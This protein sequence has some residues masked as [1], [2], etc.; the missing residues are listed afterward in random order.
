IRPALIHTIPTFNN[1]TGTTLPLER[2]RH[3]AE[4]VAHE[5]RIQTAPTLLFED[6][7]YALT[8]FEGGSLPALFDL[9]GK[10]S[11]YSSSFSATLGPGLRV[12]W[13]IVPQTLAAGLAGSC[14]PSTI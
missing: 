9:T 1:P 3:L 12:G 5:Q 10:T 4:L 13:L 2:R 8:R 6:D 14:R 11:I 7:A